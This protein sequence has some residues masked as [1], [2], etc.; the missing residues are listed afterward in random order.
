MR[1]YIS[2]DMEGISGVT[3]WQDVI[4]TGQDYP[5]ARS[6]MTADVNAAVAG[7]RAAGATEFVVEENHGV[8]MLCNLVLDEID[9]VD[10]VRGSPR[11]GATTMAA[12]DGSFDAVFLVG[13]HAK[14]R[15][16]PGIGAHTI[17]YG[18]Y[19]DVRLNGATVGEPEMFIIAA[20]QHGVP[21]ALIA[22]DDVV[23]AEVERLVPG[24]STAVVKRALSH[25]AG[26]IVPPVRA[27]RAIE[28]AASVAVERV[29][30]RQ[31]APIEFAPSFELEVDLRKPLTDEARAA[32]ADRFPEFTIVGDRT[33]AFHTDDMQVAFRRA[34]ICSFLAN[35]PASVRHY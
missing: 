35:A 20:S 5:R 18:D 1:V 9:P 10:V 24:V 4:A 14:A 32:I 33:L 15:D 8:E 12:L 17:S 25:T 2:V 31:V 27:R 6:W 7:A 29:R 26:V 16:Y 34:A 21:T 28:A 13:H 22:G 23:C 3:R 19:A 30:E 11:G